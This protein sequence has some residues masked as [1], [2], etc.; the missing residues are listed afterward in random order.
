MLLGAKRITHLMARRHPGG[1]SR[2]RPLF[3]GSREPRPTC[4]GRT[5][6]RAPPPNAPFRPPISLFRFGISVSLGPPPS[7]S[8]APQVV[9]AKPPA[10]STALSAKSSSQAHGRSCKGNGKPLDQ[11]HQHPKPTRGP[12]SITP[13]PIHDY[14][15]HLSGHVMIGMVPM[16]W[17]AGRLRAL[18]RS[19]T[20]IP[21]ER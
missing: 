1:P 14:C 4:S 8:K 7:A 13:T 19:S 18:R 16:R 6:G 20:W 15:F 9:D 21:S 3:A 17:S 5:L 10:A 2:S 12:A 11:G